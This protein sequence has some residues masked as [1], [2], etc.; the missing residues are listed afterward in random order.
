M[1]LE[2]MLNIRV[3]KATIFSKSHLHGLWLQRH[4][5][6]LRFIA[7]DFHSMNDNKEPPSL[8]PLQEVHSCLSGILI[9]SFQS[10]PLINCVLILNWLIFSTWKPSQSS[11][12]DGGRMELGRKE[13]PTKESEAK[14]LGMGDQFS[15]WNGCSSFRTKKQKHKW[16]GIDDLW[17]SLKNSH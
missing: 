17:L 7:E 14:E 1:F 9:T 10:S 16:L 8:P 3:G 6:G 5:A 2:E 13:S 4:Y 15:V 11:W 12:W